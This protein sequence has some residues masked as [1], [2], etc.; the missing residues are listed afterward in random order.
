MVAIF[1]LIK[2]IAIKRF[3]I[4]FQIEFRWKLL[5]VDNK[6]NYSLFFI[7]SIRLLITRK[8]EGL[9]LMRSMLKLKLTWFFLV[10]LARLIRLI[11]LI[12]LYFWAIG[13]LL[14]ENGSRISYVEGYDGVVIE[15]DADDCWS[16]ELGVYFWLQEGIIGFEERCADEVFHFFNSWLI[17]TFFQRAV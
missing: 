1:K 14:Y 15:K 10:G 11:I 16:A 12:V 5:I 2:L 13:D 3:K 4:L 9:P 17:D 7:L 6:I 8:W